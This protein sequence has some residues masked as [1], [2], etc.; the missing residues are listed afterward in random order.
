VKAPS[1]HELRKLNDELRGKSKKLYRSILRSVVGQWTTISGDDTLER[2]IC[3]WDVPKMLSVS[4]AIVS[5]KYDTAA[6]HFAAHQIAALIRKYPW[7]PKESGIDPEAVAR[8]SFLKNERR[9]AKVNKWF[10]ARRKRV[11]KSV[12]IEEYLH[13]SREWIRY[14]LRDEPP[15]ARIYDK[16]DLTGG[17]NVGV[18][19]D[20]TNLA[21]KLLADG[22]TVTPTAVPYF[23]AALC[24]NFHY[25]SR[26]GARGVAGVQ[27]LQVLKKDLYTCCTVVDYNK[28]GFVLKTAETHRVMAAEPLALTY[29]QK[30]T[31]LVMRDFLR[32]VGLDL[33]WQGPN[34]EMAR[35]GSL[36]DGEEGF[37]TLDLKDASAFMSLGLCKS[38]LPPDWFNFLNR[39]RSPS[40]RLPGEDRSTPYQMFVSMG[41]GFCF[42]LQ[43]LLFASF[44]HAVDPTARPG[45]DFRVYGDDIIVRKKIVHDVIAL[46]KRVGFK[47][48]KRK[49]CVE[50]PF[51]ESCGANWYNGEDVTPMTLDYALD[52]LENMFK[53][54]N[55]SRRN[56]FTRLFLEDARNA[57][58][59]SLPD[60]FLFWRPF[61][62]R[63]ETG[64]DPGGLEFT[65]RWTTHSAWQCP[66]WLELH[67]VPVEDR[68][69]ITP[70][71]HWVVMA[72]ALRGHPSGKPFVWRRRVSTRVVRV[73]AGAPELPEYAPSRQYNVWDGRRLR[74][75][76]TREA[77]MPPTR[78]HP[79]LPN[80]R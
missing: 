80:P 24:A 2:A 53:F 39:I 5:Q 61:K 31:D 35:K 43:T 46:L 28:V 56:E 16:C 1:K 62:G 32:R 36:D 49:T 58:I 59:A 6:R 21:R 65:P 10:I 48:N 22:W 17:A 44:V 23:A 26:T 52:S 3:S 47:T 19:G 15:L 11:G 50:G 71:Q 18:H 55:L 9:V 30:G 68:I 64:L 54:I 78:W 73:A 77:G 51:R 60:K 63:P 37:A 14:V 33:R 79:D 20:L 66:V 75:Y 45:V 69:V 34:Q 57:V 72:A 67:T 76:Y 25:A 74:A 40:Y 12:P 13:R 7:T 41:N 4:G 70:E 42:P 8:A 27:C 38:Q 29:L